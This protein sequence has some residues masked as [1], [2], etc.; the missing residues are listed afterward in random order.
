MKWRLILKWSLS[1]VFEWV[2]T[3]KSELP[4]KTIHFGR[5]GFDSIWLPIMCSPVSECEVMSPFTNLHFKL[6][7]VMNVIKHFVKIFTT[8]LI[9][10]G[11]SSDIPWRLIQSLGSTC[12]LL[13]INDFFRH[14]QPKLKVL[15]I[16]QFYIYRWEAICHDMC[17]FEINKTQSIGDSLHVI[18]YSFL[19]TR[20]CFTYMKDHVFNSLFVCLFVCLFNSRSRIFRFYFYG[21]VTIVH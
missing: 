6:V 3:D 7:Y 15:L 5:K 18:Y 20:Q 19:I 17:T 10:N 14:C 1:A 2:Q 16:P 9:R 21:D 11:L 12:G 8:V 13:P 4:P